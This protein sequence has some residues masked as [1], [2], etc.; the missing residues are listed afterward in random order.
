MS[1]ARRLFVA[2]VLAV[3]S[4]G[5]VLGVH[6]VAGWWGVLAAGVTLVSG[7]VF[8]SERADRDRAAAAWLIQD[9]PKSCPVD[10]R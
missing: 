1:F 9:A 3:F 2:L 8:V 7:A 10:P 6:S 5:T 4:T